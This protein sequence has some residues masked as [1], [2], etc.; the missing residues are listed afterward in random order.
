MIKLKNG[1]EVEYNKDF[2]LFFKNIMETIIKESYVEVGNLK[3]AIENKELKNEQLL[4]EIMDNCIFVTHQLFEISKTNEEMAKFLVTG[5]IFNSII[6]VLPQFRDNIKN[7]DD[8][9]LH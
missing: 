4:K 6:L 2:D 7:Q 1:I 9:T 3:D 8:D 5:F